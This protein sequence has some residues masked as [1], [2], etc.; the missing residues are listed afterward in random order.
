MLAGEGVQH[1]D[2]A[3]AVGGKLAYRGVPCLQVGGAKSKGRLAP[4]WLAS[5]SRGAGSAVVDWKGRNMVAAEVCVLGL[6][7]G[8]RTEEGAV[9]LD[10]RVEAMFSRKIK[11]S[12]RVPL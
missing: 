7:G 2:G 6:G 3:M 9:A 4:A 5:P 10:A 11:T 8:G 12:P 1:R